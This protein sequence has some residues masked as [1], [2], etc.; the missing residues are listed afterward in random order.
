[1]LHALHCNGRTKAETDTPTHLEVEDTLTK[2]LAFSRVRDG[3]VE[4]TLANSQHLNTPT[5]NEWR[6]LAGR[7]YLSGDANA[8]FVEHRDGVFVSLAF[9]AQQVLRRDLREAER[10]GR[11]FSAR[12]TLQSSK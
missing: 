5:L 1:M 7:I 6:S 2:L 8:A 3:L 11:A 12:L 4:S 10:D 9:F